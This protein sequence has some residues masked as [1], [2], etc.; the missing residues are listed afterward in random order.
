MEQ[1]TKYYV[2]EKFDS[3]A[4][5]EYKT[6]NGAK[7][8]ADKNGLRVFNDSGAQ[9]YPTI[10]ADSSPTE[11]TA[12]DGA[13]TPDNISEDIFTAI[14]KNSDSGEHSKKESHS[15]DT[16]ENAP[17]EADSSPTG[18]A[19]Y[20]ISM[21]D[22]VPADAIDGSEYAEEIQSIVDAETEEFDGIPAVKTKGKIKRIF[23][24]NLRVRNSP[25]WDNSVVRG[26]TR[27][28]EKEV[29]HLL[30]VDD[31]PMY[32]TIDGYFISGAPELVKFIED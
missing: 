15:D 31:I 18:K 13:E 22:D 9:I 8:A 30:T 14:A 16:D 7:K 11:E 10:A 25:S 24:G 4:N 3:G 28:D 17:A 12:Q 1:T 29:T 5:K 20:S 19:S 32:R 2:G 21:T 27:F 23:D 26:V 6:L